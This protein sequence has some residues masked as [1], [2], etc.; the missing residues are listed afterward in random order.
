MCSLKVAPLFYVELNVATSQ[1]ASNGLIGAGFSG[2]HPGMDNDWQKKG[3][4]PK[5]L[6]SVINHS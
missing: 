2:I 1:V 3:Q 6:M 4:L 5:P